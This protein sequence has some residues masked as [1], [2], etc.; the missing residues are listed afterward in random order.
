MAQIFSRN[1]N[2][3]PLIV[4]GVVV[5]AL[6]L[7][8]LLVWY[9]AAPEY[10]D[11][12]YR[13]RQPI[14]YSHK[15]HAGDLG[16]DCRYCHSQ[17]EQSRYA[18]VPST[19]TCMNCHAVIG[20]QSE[21]LL[22][23]RE[24]LATGVPIQWVRVHD[25]PDFVY[26]DHSAHLRAGIGCFSCHGNVA[27]M[28]VVT[29]VESLSM[30]WCLD[31]HRNPAPHVRPRSEITNMNWVPGPD[32]PQTAARFLGENGISPGEDCAVCHR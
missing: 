24:S 20:K 4:L 13:P 10:T 6:V 19:Q 26:F 29:Q 1:A 32:Q 15:L 7:A 8:T 28:P 31:C 12:G 21:K 3:L 18:N 23:L 30:G 5:F 17:I 27:N 9:Y 11:V 2:R 14:P 25:L 16:M 22:P